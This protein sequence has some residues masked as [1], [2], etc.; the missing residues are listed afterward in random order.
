MK[1]ELP[2]MKHPVRVM[3]NVA[4]FLSFTHKYKDLLVLNQSS[5]SVFL[6]MEHFGCFLLLYQTLD[7]ILELVGLFTMISSFHDTQQYS[8]E[9]EK[10]F[11]NILD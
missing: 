4:L 7:K 5:L 6:C 2:K 9:K 10:V 3:T 8:I 1:P 11:S